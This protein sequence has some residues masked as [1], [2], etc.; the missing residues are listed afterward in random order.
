MNSVSNTC[1]LNYFMI[2]KFLVCDSTAVYILKLAAQLEQI[3][4]DCNHFSSCFF[5]KK[6]YTKTLKI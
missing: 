4:I 3:F 6:M 1:R 2:I 5:K